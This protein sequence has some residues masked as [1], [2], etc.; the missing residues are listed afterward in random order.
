MT[1]NSQKPKAADIAALDAALAE[2]FRE[3]FSVESFLSRKIVS[4]QGNKD[5][6][7]FRWYK[8]KEAF[9]AELVSHFL[10]RYDANP[11]PVGALS[12]RASCHN[13][14][15]KSVGALSKR[16]R[17]ILDPFAGIGTTLFAASELGIAADGIELLPIGQEIINARLI[18]E[19]DKCADAIFSTLAQWITHR[20]WRNSPK[21]VPFSTL[22]ITENAYPPET[23]KAIERYRGAML[24]EN[25]AV[26]AV[27]R[28]ALLCI[29]ESISYT[30]KDGQCLRWDT[31][32]GKTRASTKPFNKGQILGFDAAITAKLKEILD[33]VHPAPTL[34]SNHHAAEMRLPPVRLF[35]GSCLEILP[36][37]ESESYDAVLTSPPY[38]NRYDYTRTYALELAMLDLTHEDVTRLRQ[39]MLSCTVE[40]REKDLLEL[41]PQWAPFIA[42]AER[43]PLLQA[44]LAYLDNQKSEGML[45]NNGIPRM[46]RGY[47]YEMAC[48]IG[49]CARVLKP[50]A[51][52]FMVNDNVRYAGV[53][54][55]VDMILSDIARSLGFAVEQ[56]LVVPGKKGNSSQQMGVYGRV[57][58]RKCVSIWRRCG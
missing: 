31:R 57:P 16:A 5:K 56:I 36:T 14:N 8:Y 2:N 27:L 38:C 49:E 58:L 25:D 12:K 19:R 17:K 7:A 30:R 41:A 45:N 51:R 9:S 40:N 47:F 24:Q 52:L 1:T 53:S 42:A 11:S 37:L 54:I 20:P 55:S 39:Q 4:F 46:V 28:L 26:Q 32:S 44:N 48:V 21:R 35:K 15:P 18:L 13:A 33:D 22:R 3:Q 34:F 29:L 43:Q 10:S 50:N 23:V 6:P